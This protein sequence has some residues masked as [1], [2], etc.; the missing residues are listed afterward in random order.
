MV[1]DPKS[2]QAQKGKLG[3]KIVREILEEWGAKVTRPDGSAPDEENNSLVDFYA[4][5]SERNPLFKTR[6][7]EV[8]VRKAMPYAY[9]QYPC[10]SFPVVQIEAYR[11]FAR[12]QKVQ[13]DL[14]IVDPEANLILSGYLNDDDSLFNLHEKRFIDGKEFPFD[15]E[16]KRGNMRFF[17]Q[18]QFGGWWKIN[19]AD[20]SMLRGMD[21]RDDLSSQLSRYLATEFGW[22]AGSFPNTAVDKLVALEKE[23]GTARVID[24]IETE[25]IIYWDGVKNFLCYDNDDGTFEYICGFARES[26]LK[27]QVQQNK[28]AKPIDILTAPNGTNI[29]ILTVDGNEHFFV[30][31]AR[32][33]TAVGYKNPSIS[34]QSPLIV[35]AKRFGITCYRFETQRLSGG[36]SYGTKGYYFAVSDVPKVLIQYCELHYNAKSGTRQAQFNEAAKELC[37]WFRRSVMMRYGS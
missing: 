21:K 11:N 29:D 26:K 9:G 17:H 15:R 12:E 34:Q 23:C 20:L 37:D 22:Y 24:A 30:K 2:L 5:P 3:E 27:E 6:Y 33:S 16:T 7:V 18:K 36:D 4:I 10:Y 31:V 1:Y 32:V 28:F 8:K 25:S 19:D 13:L 14:W 35:A